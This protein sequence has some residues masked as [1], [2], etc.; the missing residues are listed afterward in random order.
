MN[1][2]KSQKSLFI[3]LTFFLVRGALVL[4]LGAVMLSSFSNDARAVE[5]ADPIKAL[6]VTG[7]GWHDYESQEAIITEGL[8]SRLRIDWTVEFAESRE[9]WPVRFERDNWAKG[10]DVVVYNF[11]ILVGEASDVDEIVAMHTHLNIP[12]VF[13][14]CAIHSFRADTTKWFEFGGVRSHRH[15]APRPFF[16]EVIEGEHP[17][18]A[19]FPEDGWQTPQGELYEIAEIYPTATPLA[20][21]YGQDTEQ[22]HVVI[23]TNEYEGVRVFGTTI[24]HHNETMA[25]HVYLDFVSRGLLWAIDRLDD[26]GRLRIGNESRQ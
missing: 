3:P 9:Q 5:Q 7:G 14:H 20:Q 18:M 21:A 15:E 17:I 22:N 4:G 24:G 23:W 25:H 11:C 12:A 2:A 13:I 26:N 19:G 16:V 1:S 6:Y 8:G 10:F